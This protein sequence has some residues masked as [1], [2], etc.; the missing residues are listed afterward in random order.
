MQSVYSVPQ[1]AFHSEGMPLDSARRPFVYFNMVSSV[2]GKAVSATGNASGLGSPAD[3]L[4][5]SRL[6]AASDA[7]LV[8][9]E[10]F[11]RDPF[12]PVIRPAL[13]AERAR[14]FPGQPQPWG[15]V[16]SSDGRLPPDKKFFDSERRL[17]A[18]GEKAASEQAAILSQQARVVRVPDAPEGGQPD[19]AWLLV[20]LYQELGVRRLLC[21]GGP[22]LNYSLISRGLGDELFWTL[23]P[24]LVGG[25]GQ[26]NSTILNGP[27]SGFPNG[28]TAGLELRSL[29][30]HEHELYFRYRMVKA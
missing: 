2:D 14:Y 8:G 28:Q 18:L 22:S 23:A 11:R 3:H 29:Y 25:N 7:V 12:V 20:Y 19:I 24:K 4:L 27:G 10:T 17:I 16:L 15:I 13:A 5:M 21:E 6:R 1:L 9:A 26:H 30:E